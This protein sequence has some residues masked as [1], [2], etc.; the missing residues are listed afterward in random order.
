MQKTPF[1]HSK[2]VAFKQLFENC[3]APFCIC[4]KRYI[5]DKETLEDIVSG[6]F[7]TLWNNKDS[8]EL[9]SET[10]LAYIKICVKNSCL[11]YLKHQ[12]YEYNYSEF[13]RQ[14]GGL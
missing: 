5:N 1:E 10:A 7:A 4:A 2:E 13:V 12:E 11:D 6:G 14:R 8:F 9:Y 3:Y